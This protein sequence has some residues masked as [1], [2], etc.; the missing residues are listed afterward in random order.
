MIDARERKNILAKGKPEPKAVPWWGELNFGGWYTEAEITA[1]V[2]AIRESMHW[3]VGFGPNPKT[4]KDFEDIFAQYCGAKHAIAITN[5]GVGLDMAMVCLDL[6]PGDE[7][8]CPAINY[9]ASQMAILGRGGKV[10]FCDIDPKTFNLDPED[11]EKRITPRTRAICPVHQTGLAAPIPELLDIA[12]RHAHPVYGSLKIIEDAARSC[13]ARYNG[14]RV[15]SE[16]WITAFSFH[17]QKLMTTLGEGGAVTTNDSALAARLRDMCNYGGEDGW[18]VNNRMNKVQA[19]VGLVQLSRLDEMNGMRRKAAY[20]R[21]ALLDG[22]PEI[23]L[24]YEPF[25]YEHTYYVYAILVQPEWAGTKRDKIIAI[26]RDKFGIVCSIT[27]LPTYQRWPYIARNCEF[28]PLPVSEEIGRRLFCP[29]LHPLLTD[30]QEL[31]ISASLLE[32]IDLVKNN[33]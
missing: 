2:E 3:S 15:G 25:G 30:E 8:I 13:G 17:S 12:G 27:N 33:A 20:R 7:V 16:S 28:T 24:P 32:A 11:V 14:H 18:G 23:I 6:Q 21:N 19:A 1:A 29:P 22:V 10:V 5:C 9:K 31:Y 4:V 26:L